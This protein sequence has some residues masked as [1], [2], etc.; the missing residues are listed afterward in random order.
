MAYKQLPPQVLE[1]IAERFRVLAEPN[2]LQ[3]LSELYDHEQ[4]VTELMEALGQ[5]HANVS[6]HLQLLYKFEFV[7]RRKV[8]LRVHYRL[9]NDDV[10]QLCDIMCN[11]LRAETA[12]KMEIIDAI[13]NSTA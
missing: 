5:T 9:A 12:R 4:T 8:G 6:K 7:D 13:A 2:R 1:L 3:I 11:R 10:F